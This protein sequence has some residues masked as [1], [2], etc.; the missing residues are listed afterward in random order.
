MNGSMSQ[1][2]NTKFNVAV[3]RYEKPFE[4]LKKAVD[5]A[6]GLSDLPSG[7]K[8]LIKPNM[9]VWYE[10]INFPKYGLLTT[11]R[12]IEDITRLLKDRGIDDIT[13]AEGGVES[14]KKPK[15][16]LIYQAAKGMGLNILKE[17]YGV[18]IVDILRGSFTKLTQNDV[19]LS[20]SNYVLDADYVINMPVLKTHSQTM[21]SLGMKNLKGVLNV[22]SRK[23]CHNVDP[24]RDLH[25]HIFKLLE[26]VKP[27]F[28]IV[29]GIYSLERGPLLTGRAHR[30]NIIIASK[31]TV[32]A[33]LVGS[34]ILGIDPETV[35]QISMAARFKN[36][37]T[38]LSDIDING[39][40]DIKTALKPHKWQ[41]EQNEQNTRPLYMEKAGV[42]GLYYYQ[43]DTSLCT[44]CAELIGQINLGI[45]MATNKDKGFDDVELLYGKLQKPTPGHKHT[46]LAGQ[47]Q[48]KLNEKNPLINHCIKIPGCP[49]RKEDFFR[50][51]EEAGI[52]L[53]EDFGVWLEKSP[54]IV[55]AKRYA[56]DPDFDPG[57]YEIE[58]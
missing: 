49:A 23:K 7:S 15:Y 32:S 29:D 26:A 20:I 27:S 53:P 18:K 41:F 10:G 51:F 34:S 57:F 43:V 21:V 31:D 42:K 14:E 19:K 25:Y 47:C 36:R 44:Y 2:E 30:S 48:V 9:V 55:F 11:P 1:G 5:L 37:K 8:V 35:P 46:M 56:N 22:A 40:V 3:V 28:T 17:R 13:I 6:G 4:S 50:A 38:D 54:E 39:N 45:L 12:M 24:N 58:R 52:E 33:D 16:S